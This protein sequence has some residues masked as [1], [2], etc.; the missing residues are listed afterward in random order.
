MLD[1]SQSVTTPVAGLVALQ[2]WSCRVYVPG[3]GRLPVDGQKQPPPTPQLP[4]GALSGAPFTSKTTLP[5]VP[6]QL[7]GDAVE[8]IVAGPV[9]VAPFAGL[10]MTIV[11]AGAPGNI[12]LPPDVAAVMVRTALL[13]H[14]T[15]FAIA[16]I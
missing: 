15:P 11:C 12:T 13:S 5:A 10:D 8:T 16:T 6:P 1:E 9:S 3:D 2:T 7:A 14:A 4:P